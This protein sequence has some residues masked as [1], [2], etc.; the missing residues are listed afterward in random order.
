MSDA[1]ISQLDVAE[2]LL[3]VANLEADTLLKMSQNRTEVWKVVVAA[4]TAGGA[5][6]GATVALVKVLGP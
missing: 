2:K 5:L 4:M 3:R 6:V 1:A